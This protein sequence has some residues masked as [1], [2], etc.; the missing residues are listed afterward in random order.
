MYK[1]TENPD[2]F[3]FKLLIKAPIY[4]WINHIIN[5]IS[6]HQKIIYL[7]ILLVFKEKEKPTN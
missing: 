7:I 6:P 1:I 5:K 3:F 4:D 2:Y